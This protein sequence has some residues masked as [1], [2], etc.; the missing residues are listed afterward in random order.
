MGG[1]TCRRHRTHR[2]RTCRLRRRT[3]CH[4]CRHR[5]RTCRY[6][7]TCCRLRTCHHHRTCRHCRMCYRCS[8][9]PRKVACHRGV[10]RTRSPRRRSLAPRRRSL[11]RARPRT[12]C[13]LALPPS[14]PAA[15]TA[16]ALRRAAGTPRARPPTTRA[17][18]WRPPRWAG[19]PTAWA[20]PRL[21]WG[22]RPNPRP[23]RVPKAWAARVGP[24]W[25]PL[26][27]WRGGWV[28]RAGDGVR[29]NR[30]SG[31]GR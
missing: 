21:G 28:S 5:H 3:R 2:R 16:A 9:R 22:C 13:Q 6:C 23:G 14:C 17:Q 30:S 24:T 20:G 31:K 18:R 29:G 10:R 15:P 27:A 25:P 4:T 19:A 11:R 7:H 12:R 1:R 8:Q 26:G